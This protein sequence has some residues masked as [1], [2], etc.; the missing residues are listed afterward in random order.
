MSPPSLPIYLP[1]LSITFPTQLEVENLGAHSLMFPHLAEYSAHGPVLRSL[2]Y[3]LPT[4]TP[5]RLPWTSLLCLWNTAQCLSLGSSQF[6]ICLES[7]GL[8]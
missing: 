6:Q 2:A 8:P 3:I 5:Q 7:G 4:P 1:Y